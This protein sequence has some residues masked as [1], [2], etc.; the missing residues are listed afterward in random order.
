MRLV[1]A[2][3]AAALLAL[4]AWLISVGFLPSGP[5]EI[6]TGSQIATAPQATAGPVALGVALLAGGGLLFVMLLRRR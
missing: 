4:G 5:P 6:R 2:L 1:L 3:M